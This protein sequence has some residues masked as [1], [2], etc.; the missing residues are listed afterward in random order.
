[1]RLAGKEGLVKF[2]LRCLFGSRIMM[3]MFYDDLS[4]KELVVFRYS[5]QYLVSAVQYLFIPSFISFHPLLFFFSNDFPPF[6]VD[7]LI[8]LAFLSSLFFSYLVVGVVGAWQT[9]E[10]CGCGFF[11]YGCFKFRKAVLG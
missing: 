5:S 8:P 10:R 7:E 6:P 1:M 9:N 3:G 4:L 2:G 11:F